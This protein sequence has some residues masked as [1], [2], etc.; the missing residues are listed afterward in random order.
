ME[1]LTEHELDREV[2]SWQCGYYWL[3]L[4]RI[5]R[6]QRICIRNRFFLFLFLILIFKGRFYTE[7]VLTPSVFID[8]HT[9]AS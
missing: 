5:V 2:C 7:Y 6:I 1:L 3:Y 9:L 8:Y 4:V